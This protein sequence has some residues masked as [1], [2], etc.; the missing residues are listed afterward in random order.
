[1]GGFNTFLRDCPKCSFWDQ[2]L[3]TCVQVWYDDVECVRTGHQND[4]LNYTT[5]S[6]DK[7]MFC[8]DFEDDDLVSDTWGEY[9]PYVYNDGVTVVDG[10]QCPQGNRCGFFSNESVL[11]VP[12]FSN[13]YGH[14]PNLRITLEYKMIPSSANL[15]Q[16][17]V[18]NDCFPNGNGKFAAGN[19]LFISAND[20]TFNAGLKNPIGVGPTVT[21]NV[22]NM[23][24]FYKWINTHVATARVTAHTQERCHPGVATGPAKHTMRRP[25]EP[26]R[27]R[28]CHTQAAHKA[29]PSGGEQGTR[30]S[31]ERDAYASKQPH[32]HTRTPPVGVRGC[33][34]PVVSACA[35]RGV[36]AVRG[37]GAVVWLRCVVL[38]CGCAGAV[39]GFVRVVVGCVALRVGACGVVG[40][41]RVRCVCRV[42]G[43]AALGCAVLLCVRCWRFGC[44]SGGRCV[45]WCGACLC[46][47]GWVF[48]VCVACGVRWLLCCVSWL[49]SVPVVSVLSRGA[50]LA[51]V[52]SYAW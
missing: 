21:V 13:N 28:T 38:V 43:G 26:F 50:V 29:G 30:V 48:G 34:V 14:W 1:M 10:P 7:R 20:K 4:R 32:A 49:L 35:W 47:F 40:G 12:F 37:A 52:V 15:D 19:S 45:C 46:G 3:L 16:G 23:I 31:S 5:P 39:L 36:C 22:V 24:C 42:V 51:K 41:C 18:S 11:E 17:I 27:Q 44:R 2:D 9:R 33:C 25:K 8:I 6:E